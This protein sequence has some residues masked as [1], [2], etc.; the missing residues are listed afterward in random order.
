MPKYRYAR[1]NGE[2]LQTR[3]NELHDFSRSNYFPATQAYDLRY[4]FVTGSVANQ[5]SFVSDTVLFGYQSAKKLVAWWKPGHITSTTTADLLQPTVLDSSGNS[6]AASQ[7]TKSLQPKVDRYDTPA[8]YID[9]NSLLFDRSAGTYMMAADS[10]AFTFG[11]STNDSPF[12]IAIWI[13]FT[14]VSPTQYIVTK[15]DSGS[16]LREYFLR[17]HLSGYF[18]IRLYDESAD[19]VASA[20]TA[21]GGAWVAD[22]WYHVV[23]TYAGNAAPQAGSVTDNGM[24][25]YVDG[26]DVT[27]NWSTDPSYVAMENTATPVVIGDEYSTS[28]FLLGGNIADLA[29]WKKALS[30]SEVKTLHGVSNNGAYR[31]VRRFSEISAENDTRLLGVETAGARGYNV[32]DLPSDWME[33]FRQGTNVQTF[34]QLLDYTQFKIR[35]NSG[36]VTTIGGKDAPPRAY[37]STIETTSPLFF[38]PASKYG[39]ARGRNYKTGVQTFSGPTVAGGA[40]YRDGKVYIDSVYKGPLG[41]VRRSTDPEA[42][43]DNVAPGYPDTVPPVSVY[44]Y[45]HRVG[46]YFYGYEAIAPGGW[47]DAW[48]YIPLEGG[49]N[50]SLGGLGRVSARI[51]HQREQRDLGQIDVYETVEA[52]EPFEDVGVR[53]ALSGPIFSNVTGSAFSRLDP[54][55]II[56]TPPGEMPLPRQLVVQTS[57]EV[58]DGAIEPLIIRPAIDRTSIEQPYYAHDIRASLGGMTD[59]YRR[60]MRFADG[61]DLGERNQAVPFFDATETYGTEHAFLGAGIGSALLWFSGI[62]RLYP[63]TGPEGNI[64]GSIIYGGGIDLPGA[65]ST[66]FAKITPFVDYPSDRDEIYTTSDVSPIMANMLIASGTYGDDSI[67]THKWMATAGFEFVNDPIGIDSIAYGGLKK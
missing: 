10:D 39:N 63:G 17:F 28:A 22:T 24:R 60:S 20:H 49:S 1:A 53:S 36:F 9:R 19:A 42:R 57:A 52:Y 44:G 65:F 16:S 8:V 13:K 56:K 25:I 29:V 27:D 51:S 15:W 64:T 43:D 45:A 62:A 34:S 12:T 47:I 18:T 4:S 7:A 41:I 5:N 21:T 6:H 11:D 40:V 67:R 14:S 2:F 61:W 54:L 58:T 31:L 30:A 38:F 46:T 35:P 3:I 50:V 66:D 26:V 37:D 55:E 23:A 33:G 59:A 32:T 48:N